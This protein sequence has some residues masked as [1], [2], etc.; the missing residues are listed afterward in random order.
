MPPDAKHRQ[1]EFNW[2]TDL[3]RQDVENLLRRPSNE[4]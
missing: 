4:A 2:E 3:T 1:A